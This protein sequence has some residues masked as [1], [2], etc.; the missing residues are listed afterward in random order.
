MQLGFVYLV[1]T[2]SILATPFAGKVAQHI[3]ARA[4][5]VSALAVAAAG[6]PLLAV[7]E[8]TAVL[9]GLVL[10]GCGTFFAQATATGYISRSAGEQRGAAG[11]VYL[12]SYYAGGL[13]GSLLLG[14][15][16]DRFGWNA[17]LIV[18]GSAF[19]LAAFLA[20]RLTESAGFAHSV[21]ISNR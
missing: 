15:I 20:L 5:I 2:P 8:L 16:F 3:G 17:T 9:A 1:F 21:A 13:A 4:T 18:I 6:L 11:G 12:A 19:A 14:Q 7:N 10:V